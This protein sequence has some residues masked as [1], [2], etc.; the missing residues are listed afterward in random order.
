[1]GSKLNKKGLRGGK[2]EK[3]I[4]ILNRFLWENPI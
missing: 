2:S 4:K 1:M 3:I